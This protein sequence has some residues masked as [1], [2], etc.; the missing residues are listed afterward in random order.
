MADRMHRHSWL[1][2][3]TNR[4]GLCDLTKSEVRASNQVERFRREIEEDAAREAI[5][6][7]VRRV[8]ALTPPDRI[9]GAQLVQYLRAD[10]VDRAIR[11]A[12]ETAREERG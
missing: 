3:Y 6:A 10:A 7:A 11:G 1:N 2:P 12:A 8:E 4:C 9:L 5:E